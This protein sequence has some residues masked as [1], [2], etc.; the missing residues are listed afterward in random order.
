MIN[1]I[2][3]TKLHVSRDDLSFIQKLQPDKI[4]QEYKNFVN[5]KI[6]F[7]EGKCCHER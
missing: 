7:T 4:F 5:K 1:A 6:N 3:D 2:N